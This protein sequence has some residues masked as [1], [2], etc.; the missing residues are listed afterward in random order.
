MDLRQE[1]KHASRVTGLLVV[2]VA[3]TVG[4]IAVIFYTRATPSMAV[5]PSVEGLDPRTVSAP[6]KGFAQQNAADVFS[7]R[8]NTSP[9]YDTWDAMGE[10][11]VENPAENRYLMVVELELNETKEVVFRSG[12]LRPGEKIE[13]AA[14]DVPLTAGEYKA[15]ACLCAVD[16]ESYDLLGILE[17]PVTITVKK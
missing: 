1:R 16:F 15:T 10:L 8:I 9:V 4:A 3:L 7:Y 12:Y 5:W 14:L 13:R 11:I 17:Q 6:G 2:L